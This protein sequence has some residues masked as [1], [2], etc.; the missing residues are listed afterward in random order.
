MSTVLQPPEIGLVETDRH[1][2]IIMSPVPAPS[3]GSKQSEMAYLLRSQMKSRKVVTECPI[4]TTE[5]V[6]GA[7]VAWCSDEVWQDLEGASC[8]IR[9]PELAIEIILPA[10]TRREIEE[11]KAL[12]LATGAREVWICGLDG[13]VHFW[14]GE[15]EEAA[16]KLFLEFPS[17]I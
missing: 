2:Q 9:C 3:H 14:V 12:S 17:R 13:I 6:K 10:N 1:G 11:E 5:G 15:G 8:F 16:S 7:D 4:S